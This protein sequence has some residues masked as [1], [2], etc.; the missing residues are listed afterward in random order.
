MQHARKRIQV[1]TNTIYRIVFTQH[2]PFLIPTNRRTDIKWPRSYFIYWIRWGIFARGRVP[3][4]KVELSDKRNVYS[5][6]PHPQCIHASDV[7]IVCVGGCPPFSSCSIRFSTRLAWIPLL[8]W[9]VVYWS[10]SATNSPRMRR[11]AAVLVVIPFITPKSYINIP[12]ELRSSR[13]ISMFIASVHRVRQVLFVLRCCW[14]KC[15]WLN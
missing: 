3:D 9:F 6:S 11:M 2:S 4:E 5:H 8:M 10:L 14:S 7:L 12:R 13:E 1:K 15:V